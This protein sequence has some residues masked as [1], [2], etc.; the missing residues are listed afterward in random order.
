MIIDVHAHALSEQHIREM[1]QDPHYAME[2]GDEGGYVIPGYGPI[3]PE[4]YDLAPRLRSLERRGIDVQL[5][6]PPLFPDI[7]RADTVDE[8]RRINRYTAQLQEESG[9]RLGGLI[10]LPLAEPERIPDELRRA[11]DEHGLK[12]VHL[13]TTAGG[14][15]LDSPA[16]E[17]MFATIEALGLL[18]VMHPLSAVV[19]RS[20]DDFL[21]HTLVEWP[22]ETTIA[23]AR[24]IFAGVFERHPDWRLCLCHGGG[25]LPYLTGRLDL[26]YA[27][28]RYEVDPQC[29]AHIS[30][31]PSEYVQRLYFDTVVAND[32]ALRFLID[33]VGA[34]HIMLGTDF[35]FEVGDAL[36][37]HA[38][39]TID[40]LD[41]HD[42]SLILGDNAASLLRLS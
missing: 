18:T 28:P 3:D 39:I 6:S 36:G 42:R 2:P 22:H 26:G 16:F 8:V 31:P 27:A 21:L 24:L 13:T 5:I 1:A 9:G 41:A 37:A 12:G 17:P 11:L 25:T 33:A 14:E 23:V 40:A 34:D 35:P 15:V 7:A 29:R 4:V 32:S 30:R 10:V 20:L 19:R 38:L